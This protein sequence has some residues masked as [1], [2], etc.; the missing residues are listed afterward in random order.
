MSR[1]EKR[2]AKAEAKTEFKRAAKTTKAELLENMLLEA[3]ESGKQSALKRSRANAA[4]VSS[5]DDELA[6]VFDRIRHTTGAPKS[7]KAARREMKV[8]TLAD[9]LLSDDDC[10]SE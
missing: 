5:D 4:I 7:V 9:L 2:A 6:S 3:R 8:K 10:L 1:K